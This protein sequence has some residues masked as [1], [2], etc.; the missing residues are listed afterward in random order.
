MA[1]IRDVAKKAGVSCGA[2]SAVINSKYDQV[3]LETRHR[4]LDAVEQLGYIPNRVARQLATGKHDTI[5]ICLERVTLKEFMNPYVSALIAG[6]SDSAMESDLSLLFTPMDRNTSFDNV[7]RRLPD[8]SV[9]GA[10][11]VGPITITKSIIN[12]IDDSA[13]PMVCIDGF[14]SFTKASTVDADNE[15]GMRGITQHLVSQGHDRLMYLSPTPMF[16]CFVD[17][18]RGFC[19]V[20]RENNLQ[21]DEHHIRI[22]PPE[23]VEHILIE[24]MMMESRPTGVVCAQYPHG[25]AAWRALT[26]MGLRVPEDIS[27]AV[28]GVEPS[29][30]DWW[31][32]VIET[33]DPNYEMGHCAMDVLKKLISKELQSPV[34]IRIPPNL[35]LHDCPSTSSQ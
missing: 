3:S 18:M 19:E 16:Q 11:I 10:I 25:I 7:I 22:L 15:M 9:D 24:S 20:M 2:V 12:A 31:K 35:V 32:C 23:R 4:I 21:V 8:R 33:H 13:M 1:T 34:A 26:N 14:P 17:R 27:L 29:E 28:C 5:A 6:V 30:S